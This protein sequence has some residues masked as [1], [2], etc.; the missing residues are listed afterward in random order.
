M[1]IDEDVLEILFK[2]AYVGTLAIIVLVIVLVGF[3]IRG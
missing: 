3:L 2:I 1:W